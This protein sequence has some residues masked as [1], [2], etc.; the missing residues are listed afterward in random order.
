MIIQM[1]VE[2]SKP[3]AWLI[4][5]DRNYILLNMQS[6]KFIKC[7]YNG[8]RYQGPFV[9]IQCRSRG[10]SSIHLVYMFFVQPKKKTTR[11]CPHLVIE[12][13]AEIQTKVK[14]PNSMLKL[15][16]L[17][18]QHDSQATSIL[19]IKANPVFISSQLFFEGM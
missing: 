16:K 9:R 13:K 2:I 19:I 3:P 8:S 12:H 6:D 1:N 18:D 15:W 14:T 10:E 5:R 7:S 4:T 17:L 11:L